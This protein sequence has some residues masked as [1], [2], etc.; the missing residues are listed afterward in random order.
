VDTYFIRQQLQSALELKIARKA[1]V[2]AELK[3]LTAE[4]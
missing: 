3:N 2:E 1:A 4:I